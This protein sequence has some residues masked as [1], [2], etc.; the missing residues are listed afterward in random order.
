MTW[1]EARH[2]IADY[3]VRALL[4]LALFVARCFGVFVIL[5]SIAFAY[6]HTRR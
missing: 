2:A 1:R 3:T 5:A 4:W 6:K